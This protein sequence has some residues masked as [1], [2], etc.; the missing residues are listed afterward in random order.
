MRRSFSRVSASQPR[1]PTVCVDCRY[2]RE[3]PSGIG[4][5]VQVLVDYLPSLAPE[6]SFLFMKHPKGPERLSNA[7]N[8][9]ECVV[10]QEAN[11]PATLFWL[12]RIV[13]LREVGLY[14]NTFGLMPYAMPVPTVVTIADIMQIKH[15]SWAKGPELWGWV[16]VAFKRHGLQR[17]LRHAARIVAVSEATRSEIASVDPEAAQRTRVALQG[18]SDDFHR[19]DG[20]EGK[21]L[22]EG[23]R[24]R[25]A[26]GAPRYVLTVGQFSAYKNHETVVRAFGR[27][28]AHDKD[29][30]LVL[31]QRLGNGPRTL[32][33]IA[34]ALGIDDRVHFIRDVP[35]VDLVALYN[36]AVALAHPSLYEG[37][38]NPVIEALACGCPVVTSNRSSMPEVAAGAALL[39]DPE[40][41]EQVADALKRIATDPALAS[42][43]VSKGLARAA[44]LGWE[45]FA[46]VHVDV[47]REVLFG[48][49][50]APTA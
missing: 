27:A 15:P 31:V 18:V 29:M 49:A 21:R 5:W 46:R 36:G 6:L 11:G 3:R 30:H 16:E 24:K 14:H 34:R 8:A 50:G 45:S 22:I 48:A 25:W 40:S 28:F 35:L 13:D 1:P 19:M 41:V 12:P 33:P 38:G 47:Y 23:A 7:P 44:E 4:V 17:A 37:Y 39:V 42:S 43:L 32:R 9:R 10:P 20:A 2:I 26:H